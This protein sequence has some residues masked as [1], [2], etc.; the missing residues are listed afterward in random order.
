MN[1][2]LTDKVAL[3]TGSSRGLGAAMVTKLA[4]DGAMVAINYFNNRQE[5][6]KVKEAISKRR[7][8]G[9]I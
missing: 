2:N 6:L 3:V 4:E 9:N 8:G 5:A 1:N 7:P